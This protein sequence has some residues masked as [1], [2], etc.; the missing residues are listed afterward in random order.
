M[1]ERS[2]SGEFGLSA[3]R[4]GR[5]R[6]SL[7]LGALSLLRSPGRDPLCLPVQLTGPSLELAALGASHA[8]GINVEQLASLT[9]P[10][11]PS[12]LSALPL[13]QGRREQPDGRKEPGS[14]NVAQPRA[15]EAVGGF[16]KVTTK[17]PR[18]GLVRYPYVS[19]AFI[20][21]I[22]QGVDKPDPRGPLRGCGHRGPVNKAGSHRR[23]VGHAPCRSTFRAPSTDLPLRTDRS[24]SEGAGNRRQLGTFSPGKSPTRVCEDS[25]PH[26]GSTDPT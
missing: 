19:D 10:C 9:K 23:G 4:I 25:Y 15:H 17:S 14:P 26:P 18:Q 12:L 5:R 2:D 11:D 20:P 24:N 3:Q 22:H 6:S 1:N 7:G 21:G 8:T 16:P 13:P